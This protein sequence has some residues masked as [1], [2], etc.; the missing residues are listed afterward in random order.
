[1]FRIY[2]TEWEMVEVGLM[3][4]LSSFYVLKSKGRTFVGYCVENWDGGFQGRKMTHVLMEGSKD[5]QSLSFRHSKFG[6][7]KDD[8]PT[9][10]FIVIKDKNMF[11]VGCTMTFELFVQ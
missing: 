1:M 8:K 9:I 4:P 5:G 11:H 6:G 2:N 10:D 3:N 7:R